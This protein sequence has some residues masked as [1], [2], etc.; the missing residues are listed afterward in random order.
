MTAADVRVPHARLIV[1]L[2]GL[3]ACGA[4]LWLSRTYTF[5]FDEWTFISTAPTWTFTSFF[6][7]HNEHPSMLFRLVYWAL[8]NTVG[9]RSYL[10]YMTLLMLA[11]LANV[12]LLFE[13]L[14]RRSG[15]AVAL[16]AALL[17]LVLGAGWEDLLWAFQMAWLASVACGLGALL[18]MQTPRRMAPATVLLAASLSF[19]AIGMVFAT[20]AAV[21]LL[22]TPAR[23]RQLLWLAPIGA[24][25]LAWYV[26]FGRFG[27]HPTPQPTPG[28]LLVDPLYAVWGLGQSLAGLVGEGGWVGVPL[29]G[30]GIVALAWYWRRHGADPLLVGVAAGLVVFY[31]VTGL[32]RAQLGYEQSGA[33]RYVYV[34]A[35]AWLILLAEP[36]SRLP[37]RGTWRP[38]LAAVLFLACFNSGIL[39]FEFTAAKTVQ[40]QRQVADLQAMAAERSDPCLDRGAHADPLVMPQ[41][42]PPAYYRAVDRY[43]DPVAGL[44]V[45]DK[46]DFEAARAH[47]RKAGC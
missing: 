25:L 18:V 42:T 7:P 3:V 35:V 1:V 16:G 40:M 39:L 31:L 24:A 46:G 34:G 41:V 23:R 9:L 5:Y 29:L 43:G 28:N 20:A 10:P 4:I 37:W 22:L 32:A 33:S 44:P 11:H 12:V 17:L 21:Q 27:S 15:D 38:A 45:R 30:A 47:L 14:R 8:L 36:A 6:E 19:S 2:A 26:V 13:L